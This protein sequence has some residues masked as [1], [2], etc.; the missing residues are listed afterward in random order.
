MK[1]LALYEK[2]GN[3]QSNNGYTKAIGLVSKAKELP[4]EYDKIVKT[5]FN[6]VK[7][8]K[9]VFADAEISQVNKAIEIDLVKMISSA[10]VEGDKR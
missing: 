3:T 2:F 1:S 9:D 6:S 5:I 4:E 7:Q 10:I 8:E